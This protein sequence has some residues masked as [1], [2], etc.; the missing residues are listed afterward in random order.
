MT[1]GWILKYVSQ[2]KMIVYKLSRRVTF[3]P[4]F[5]ATK[6]DGWFFDEK[7]GRIILIN[8]PTTT[9]YFAVLAYG[10]SRTARHYSV[11]YKSSFFRKITGM[12]ILATYKQFIPFYYTPRRQRP[13]HLLYDIKKGTF[14]GRIV[15]PTKEVCNRVGIPHTVY[16][17]FHEK[18]LISC[19]TSG[20]MKATI[21]EL[22]ESSDGKGYCELV[23]R[24]GVRV[25]LTGDPHVMNRD[26]YDIVVIVGS[27]TFVAYRKENMYKPDS[28]TMKRRN[29]DA[30]KIGPGLLLF[31][32]WHGLFCVFLGKRGFHAVAMKE[33]YD[34]KEGL[35]INGS[36]KITFNEIGTS[37][38]PHS[39]DYAKDLFTKFSTHDGSLL[40]LIQSPCKQADMKICLESVAVYQRIN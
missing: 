12:S 2:D 4:R 32:L 31:D 3:V 8:F 38:L 7:S 14:S 27:R 26:I 40:H 39:N 30:R 16:I 37:F 1:A 28:Y 35:L 33:I 22:A 6:N 36:G 23:L 20:G 24:N 17:G 18:V 11:L 9:P 13:R 5:V 19:Q 21:Y 10:R 34:P 29:T 15:I 25:P